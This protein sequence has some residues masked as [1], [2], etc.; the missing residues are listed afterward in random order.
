MIFHRPSIVHRH[1]GVTS[2]NRIARSNAEGNFSVQR[3]RRVEITFSKTLWRR[4]LW[5]WRR[6]S[7]CVHIPITMHICQ[8]T[9]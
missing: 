3:G 8:R 6:I 7:D 1:R 9:H 4:D 2:E 5:Q